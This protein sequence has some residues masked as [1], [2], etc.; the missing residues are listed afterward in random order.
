MNIETSHTPRVSVVIP[1]YNNEKYIR[2]TLTSLKEQTYTSFE[3]LCIDDG[4]TDNSSK[5]IQ[6]YEAIDQRFHYIFQKNSG[7]GSARNNGLSRAKGEFIAFLDGDDLYNSNFLSRMIEALDKTHADV[8]ICE[9]ESFNSKD[10][11][12]VSIGTKYNRFDEGSLYYT[13]EL[14]NGFYNLVSVVCWDKMYRHSFLRKNPYLF[15]NLRHC[16]DVAF[17]CSTMAAAETVCFVKDSLVRYRIGT[18]TSTQDKAVKH[19]LCAMEAFGKARENVYNLHKS[20][21]RWQ[22]AIEN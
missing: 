14:V 20:D 2:E 17:V 6:E 12:T 15:Q 1:I 21:A 4:S 10:N 7:A 16:N 19:P 9:R 18:G 8:S 5:I 22:K 13:H 11:R 3:A